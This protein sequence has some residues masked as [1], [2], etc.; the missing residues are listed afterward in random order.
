MIEELTGVMRVLGEICKTHQV[1]T[2][3]TTVICGCFIG[4]IPPI[5]FS[6]FWE[7]CRVRRSF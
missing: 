1:L 7:Y 3:V 6:S 5:F 4:Q 2:I